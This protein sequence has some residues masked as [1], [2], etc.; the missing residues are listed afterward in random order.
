LAAVE[1]RRATV[2]IEVN[3]ANMVVV[4]DEKRAKET[5]DGWCGRKEGVVMS[6]ML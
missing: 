6:E 3:L 5:G 2:K 4:E 1:A